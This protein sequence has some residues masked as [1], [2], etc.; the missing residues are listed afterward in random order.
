MDNAKAAEK[1]EDDMPES[2]MCPLTQEVLRDPV[3]DPEGNS[4]ERSAIESWLEK[5]NTSPIT[6]KPL[7]KEDLVPNRALREVIAEHYKKKVRWQ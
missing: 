7:R 6:R 5:N 2:F 1:K 4:Y 3:V